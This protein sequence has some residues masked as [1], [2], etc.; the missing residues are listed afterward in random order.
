MKRIALVAHDNRKLDLVEWVEYNY[1]VLL[2][3]IKYLNKDTVMFQEVDKDII[4][5]ISYEN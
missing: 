5:P 4:N 3:L 2:A 1:K